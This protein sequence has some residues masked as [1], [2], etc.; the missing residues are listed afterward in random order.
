MESNRKWHVA[1]IMAESLK[2]KSVMKIES[3]GE[4]NE[5]INN[6]EEMWQVINLKIMCNGEKMAKAQYAISWRGAYQLAAKPVSAA[7]L[8]G[9]C[10]EMAFAFT[11]TACQLS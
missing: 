2:A 10:S 3:N 6:E 7:A 11:A 1:K 8:I 5:I 4:E 9:V